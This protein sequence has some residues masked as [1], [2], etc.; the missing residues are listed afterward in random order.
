M[1]S[2]RAIADHIDS[3]KDLYAA[4]STALIA[5]N[6]DR[7]L[8][9]LEHDLGFDRDSTIRLGRHDDSHYEG[10]DFWAVVERARTP[11][12]NLTFMGA[13]L[14][15]AVSWIGDQLAVERYFDDRLGAG[16]KRAPELEFL[17]HLR[18]A[19]SHGNR[20]HFTNDEP[21]R[22]AAFGPFI[23]DE[24]LHGYDG[25]LFEYLS[26]GD[27]FQ[28]MDDVAQHLRSLDAPSNSIDT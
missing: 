15:A 5:L 19:V 24:S 11:E 12:S 26:T 27:I 25:V 20:W 6:D 10:I 28:L 14:S 2:P 4:G 16:D 13:L 8:A 9:H 3:L 23:L 17:R 7:Y 18:N 22:P 21:R 1:P